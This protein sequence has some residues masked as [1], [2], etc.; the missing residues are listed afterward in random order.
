[1]ANFDIRLREF[2]AVHATQEDRHELLQQLRTAQKPRSLLVQA[3]LYR[4][5]ELNSYVE[6]IEFLCGMAS[7][8]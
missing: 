7:R 8:K 1:M 2:I 6:W 3:F 5:R 4:L